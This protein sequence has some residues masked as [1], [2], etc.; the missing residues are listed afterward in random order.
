MVFGA[1]RSRI[2]SLLYRLG[3]NPGSGQ[4]LPDCVS[5]RLGAD[6]R[7]TIETAKPRPPPFFLRTSINFS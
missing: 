2:R 1:L 3:F 5:G 7:R 6:P 4:L